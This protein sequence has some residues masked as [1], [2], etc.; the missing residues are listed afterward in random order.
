MD[1][2]RLPPMKAFL[3]AAGHGT[4]LKPFTDSVP[5]CLL[6]IR[7]EP[8]L[9]IWLGLCRLH[10]ITEVLINTHAHSAAVNKFLVEHNHGLKIRISEEPTLL[11]SAG[12]L[13]ANREWVGTDPEFFVLY[14]DVLTN[15]NLSSMAQFHRRLNQMA[16]MGVYEVTNPTQCGIASLDDS[17]IVRDFVEKPQYPSSNLAFSGLLVANSKVLQFLPSASPADIGFHLLPQLVGRM[18]A[19]RMRDYLLDIGTPE[20]YAY[21]QETWPGLCTK[22]EARGTEE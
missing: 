19:F 8:L 4:R 2:F 11:G 3:L 1:V 12:T 21:A 10:G 18:V 20:K 22:S 14:A 7:G 6:P 13:V 15:A 9:G 17:G 5:K 16:T